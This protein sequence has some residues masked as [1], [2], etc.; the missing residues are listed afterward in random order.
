MI[1][2]GYRVKRKG[3]RRISILNLI[4]ALFFLTF[5]FTLSPSPFT[6][7]QEIPP[8]TKKDVVKNFKA[9]LNT[10]SPFGSSEGCNLKARGDANCD[11]V[12]NQFDLSIWEVE[13]SSLNSPQRSDFNNDGVINLLDFGVWRGTFYAQKNSGVTQYLSSTVNVILDLIQDPEKLA[14]IPGQAWNDILDRLTVSAQERQTKPPELQSSQSFTASSGLSQIFSSNSNGN[15]QQVSFDLNGNATSSQ[16]FSSN[17]Q[18]LAGVSFLESGATIINTEQDGIQVQITKSS[19]GAV[20]QAFAN[21]DGS[22]L[23]IKSWPTQA[24]YDAGEPPLSVT[25]PG[26]GNIRNVLNIQ[27]NGD[28]ILEKTDSLGNVLNRNQIR[29]N[30]TLVTE[31]FQN[32]TLVQSNSQVGFT[33]LTLDNNI[34][35]KTDYMFY[36]SQLYAVVQTTSKGEAYIAKPLNPEGTSWNFESNIS[37]RKS[38][39]TVSNPITELKSSTPDPI[40]LIKYI[41]YYK[42]LSSNPSQLNFSDTFPT[43][44]RTLDPQI[45]KANNILTITNGQ[46]PAVLGIVNEVNAQQITQSDDPNKSAQVNGYQTVINVRTDPT[47]NGAGGPIS[48]LE[49]AT[50]GPGPTGGAAQ[51]Q[52]GSSQ[53][54]ISPTTSIPPINNLD[55]V[56]AAIRVTDQI[57][58]QITVDGQSGFL[59]GNTAIGVPRDTKSLTEMTATLPPAAD[60]LPGAAPAPPPAAP[61]APAAQAPS[62]EQLAK[63]AGDAADKASGGA[64]VKADAAFKA[65]ID[66]KAN[67]DQ[68]SG[69]AATSYMIAAI[70]E[71]KDDPA[72]DPA[73]KNL[74]VEAR[75]AGLNTEKT[76]EAGLAAINAQ[77]AALG[78]GALA[79]PSLTSFSPPATTAGPTAASAAA[80]VAIAAAGLPAVGSPFS[81]GNGFTGTI[82]FSQNGV[83]TATIPGTAHGTAT[84]TQN[85]KTVDADFS[86]ARGSFH[87][88]AGA[89]TN[90]TG[91]GGSITGLTRNADGT[92]G[93]AAVGDTSFIGADGFI[94]A[95][96]G[97]AATAEE[98]DAWNAQARE[99]GLAT[100]AMQTGFEV[101]SDGTVKSVTSHVTAESFC[102]LAGTLI[103][104]PNGPTAI[105]TLKP[106]DKVYSYNEKTGQKQIS[107]FKELDINFVD[108]YLIINGKIHATVYHPFYIVIPDSIRDPDR[109]AWIPGQAWND[110]IVSGMTG[111]ITV[112]ADELKIGD[113]LPTEKGEYVPVYSIEKVKAPKTTV[114]NLMNVSL[115]NN[116]YAEGILV[117]NYASEEDAQAGANP[118]DSW[119]GDYNGGVTQDSAPADNSVSQSTEQGGNSVDA[120]GNFGGESI[121]GG[122]PGSAP[123][124][125]ESGNDQGASSSTG[126]GF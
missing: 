93:L 53:T 84:F 14:W 92:I 15:T 67:V 105:E 75:N 56:G 120:G 22:L 30:G 107:D 81:F 24:S 16:L 39:K 42:S 71:A 60:A 83:I 23:A 37:G 110:I 104:T 86:D 73:G 54:V 121:G 90:M 79:A 26:Q 119:T 85:L 43:T 2:Q 80:P 6:Y 49:V 57:T 28:S 40:E 70:R 38:E 99:Q 4:L 87:S 58:S 72:W 126:D 111:L 1:N 122:D 89:L 63:I 11:G 103:S 118:Y 96:A 102:F 61:A 47:G 65:A 117:H 59:P 113:I 8:Q 124:T 100:G 50:Y 9:N 77:R 94:E 125:S 18:Q 19:G 10:F 20:I 108:E 44:A 7:A 106:G 123:G 35:G 98:R 74:V 5:P 91:T 36:Q 101:Q 27:P 25:V 64:G 112:R 45:K 3:F 68:A 88:E 32:K 55:P 109:L 95:G 62:I 78:A 31:D 82:T 12:V 66:A 46:T 13:F 33:T 69:L 17:G 41:N 115:N 76:V 34:G 29:A 48:I 97:R 52:L 21:P 114:Y 116:F 51:I